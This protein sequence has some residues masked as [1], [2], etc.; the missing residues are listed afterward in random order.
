ME[1]Y[2][3]SGVI[4]S[5]NKQILHL[6]DGTAGLTIFPQEILWNFHKSQN[7]IVYA[8]SHV[9]PQK[10]TE[11]SHEDKTTLLAQA[12]A[13]SPFLA[14]M[15]TIS[16]IDRPYN[17]DEILFCETCYFLQI[18]A[19]EEWLERKSRLIQGK[20]VRNWE[21]IKEWEIYH[22][23]FLNGSDLPTEEGK[24]D[25]YGNLLIHRSYR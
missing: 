7:G 8:L 12:L 20:I 16:E 21:I 24:N 19:K 11:L 13:M 17:T 9:H 22:D 14:R 4:L 25:W 15:I 18:E 1:F 2:R 23:L 10:M 6:V 5:P 3:E